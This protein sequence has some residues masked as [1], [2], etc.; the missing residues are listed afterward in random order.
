VEKGSLPRTVLTATLTVLAVVF[1]LWLVYMLR[2]PIAWIIVAGFLAIALSGPVAWLHRYMPRGRA[3]LFAYMT[4]IL[5]PLLLLAII[6]PPIVRTGSNFIEH[7]PQYSQQTQDWVQKNKQLRKLDKDFN[8]TQKIQEKANELPARVGDAASWLGSLGLGLV[9][10]LFAG[11]T[12]LILSI[13]MLSN[14]RRWLEMLLAFQPPERAARIRPT[15]E[16]MGDAVGAYIAGALFQALVAGITT[17]I[18]LIILGVPFAA[19]LAVIMALFDLIPMVGATI[20]AVIIGVL[21][22][23]ATFPID[24]IIWTVWAIAY[25]QLENTVIQPRIQNRAVGIHP[26]GVIV[27]VLFGGTLFGVPG[28]LLAVPVAAMIQ[29]GIRDWLTPALPYTP[30]PQE[31]ATG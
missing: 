10:S 25:Q 14:G 6:V 31:A 12:I 13:F 22:L 29:I 28:A 11:V 23:F 24:T 3:I 30:P 18:V 27:A 2:K 7:I 5:T 1:V 19:P 8:I 9:N 17:Y 15:L 4:V 20:G 16:K 21:T 26:F